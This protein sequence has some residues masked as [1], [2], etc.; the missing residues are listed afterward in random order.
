MKKSVTTGRLE[1]V[2]E[3]IVS[4][5]NLTIANAKNVFSHID[6][7]FRD[8]KEI[9]V[10]NHETK[11]LICGLKEDSS[12]EDIFSSAKTSISDDAVVKICLEYSLLE[13]Q[14]MFFYLGDNNVA[15]VQSYSDG[16]RINCYSLSHPVVWQAKR[17]H[18]FVLSV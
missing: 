11:L 16:L 10:S 5:G 4:Q 9:K 15:R 3:V 14:S 7:A 17:G 6:L 18:V 8:R 1:T 13:K 2:I 12:F